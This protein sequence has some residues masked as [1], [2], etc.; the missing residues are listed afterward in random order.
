MMNATSRDDDLIGMTI[1]VRYRRQWL[2]V[3]GVNR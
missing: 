1:V 2:E 3:S